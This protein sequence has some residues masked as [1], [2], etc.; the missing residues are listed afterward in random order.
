MWVPRTG[1]KLSWGTPGTGCPWLP[2]AVDQ[3]VKGDGARKEIAAASPGMMPPGEADGPS[4]MLPG[5]TPAARAQSSFPALRTALV[6]SIDGQR[7]MINHY[8]GLGQRLKNPEPRASPL[9]PCALRPAK[10]T[11]LDEDAGPKGQH[12][13]TAVG[14]AMWAAQGLTQV[15]CKD[16]W[17]GDGDIRPGCVG[18]QHN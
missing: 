2:G 1:Q 7:L 5:P 17:M 8:K 12:E 11:G 13:T 6:I 16:M 10:H 9:P 15:T 14:R 18:A 3:A 4:L